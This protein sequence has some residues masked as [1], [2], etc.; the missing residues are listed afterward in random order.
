MTEGATFRVSS[1]SASIELSGSELFVSQQI[2][3]LKDMF[4]MVLAASKSENSPRSPSDLKGLEDSGDGIM[5][6]QNEDNGKNPYPSVIDVLNGKVKIT[7]AIKGS[8]TAE[9]TVKCVLMY[10]WAKDRLLGIATA[11]SKELREVCKEHAALDSSNFAA[12]LSSRKEYFL[13]DGAAGSSLKTHKLT[14]PGRMKAE[15]LLKELNEA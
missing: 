8:N 15:E 1:S 11:D 10:L 13:I 7:K 12:H 2:E 14:V 4:L 6:T 5:E 3:S 9:K